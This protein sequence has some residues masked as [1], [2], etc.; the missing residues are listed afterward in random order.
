MRLYPLPRLILSL[1]LAVSYVAAAGASAAEKKAEDPVAAFEKQT[2]GQ[3]QSVRKATQNGQCSEAREAFKKLT[4]SDYYRVESSTKASWH[5]TAAQLHDNCD[6]DPVTAYKD[7]QEYAKLVPPSEALNRRLAALKVRAD[8]RAERNALAAAAQS[9]PNKKAALDASLAAEEAE[10]QAKIRSVDASVDAAQ[11]AIRVA[12]RDLASCN[13][14]ADCRRRA[15]KPLR[16]AQKRFKRAHDGSAAA[17]RAL[18]QFYHDNNIT[19]PAVP[20]P[21][22]DE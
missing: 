2:S 10:L 6:R 12:E 14:N 4:P 1:A 19:P 21:K 17:E 8:K 11:A 16:E 15:Q 13:Y 9:D 18:G 3:L 7:L 22:S 20:K 5:E